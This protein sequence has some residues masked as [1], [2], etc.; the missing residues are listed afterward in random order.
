LVLTFDTIDVPG[1]GRIPITASVVDLYDPD[2]E[3]ARKQTKNLDLGHEGEIKAEGPGKLKRYGTLAGIA[4]T[5]TALGGV[6]GAAIGIGV[7]TAVS[8]IFW[9]GT[10][11]NLPAGTGLVIEIDRSV[12]FSVPEVP[13][14]VGDAPPRR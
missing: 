11:V 7:G 1:A 9:K 6:K 13:T 10:E 4:A 14:A 5:G 3:E 8:Y 2:D 12:A